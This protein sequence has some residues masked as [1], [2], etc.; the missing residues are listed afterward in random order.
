MR[1]FPAGY[2][3]FIVDSLA[4]LGPL[5]A[6]WFFLD[7]KSGQTDWKEWEPDQQ[8]F[9]PKYANISFRG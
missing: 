2:V 3:M 6:Y 7:Y 8:S 1:K 9:A 4:N 5:D